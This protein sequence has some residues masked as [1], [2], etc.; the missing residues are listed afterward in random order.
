[1]TEKLQNQVNGKEWSWKN[2]NTVGACDV[3]EKEK[4][5][6]A[7]ETK[8]VGE[9]GLSHFELT[10]ISGACLTTRFQKYPSQF[11]VLCLLSH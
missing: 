5:K 4:E 1:M 3:N 10:V 11:F 8:L 6:L 7:R 2:L 9:R